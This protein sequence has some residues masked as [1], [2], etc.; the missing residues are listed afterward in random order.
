MKKMSQI[1]LLALSLVLMNKASSVETKLSPQGSDKY[2]VYI[3]G[4]A[5]SSEKKLRDVFQNKVNEICGTRFE[6]ISIKIDKEESKKNI[7]NGSFKC[8]VNSQM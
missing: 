1:L 7:L 5:K 3:K 6:I 8:F 4:D 2:N